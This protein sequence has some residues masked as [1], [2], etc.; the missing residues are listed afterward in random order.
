[1][2]VCLAC[3][4]SSQP[5]SPDPSIL[6][7][8]RDS[9]ALVTL[10]RPDR[11][12]ALTADMGPNYAQLLRDLD[13]DP[14]TRAIVV[15]GAGR[16]FCSGAD[17]ATLGGS[18]DE[19]Q[20]YVS[21]QDVSTLP[22]VA[23]TLGTP[24]ATAING[25]CAGIG[26]VLAVSADARFAHPEATMSTTFAGLGLVAEY[27]IA[28][29]LPRLIGLPAATDLLLTARTITGV[30]AAEIGLAQV[31]ADPLADALAWAQAVATTS[32][33]TSVAT[34]KRQLLESDSLSL[35]DSVASSLTDMSR[36]F[37]LPDLAEALT[38][39][40]EKRAPQFP[41]RAN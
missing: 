34:M 10:N 25:P 18:V 1:V 37:E 22:V 32:S 36:A 7:E 17:L 14:G 40:A 11:L 26:F 16:G 15:T 39:R 6:L 28:W 3:G 35:R 24:V 33:P 19:L 21:G 41:P 29:L 30:Q 9:V 8:F 4:V 5:T 23:L 2:R 12:N 38:A 20:G 27:G 13:A 31:S